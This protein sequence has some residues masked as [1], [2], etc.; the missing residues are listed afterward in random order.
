MILALECAGGRSAWPLRQAAAL[1]G[2]MK[3]NTPTLAP[4]R[5]GGKRRPEPES[6]QGVR[7][8]LRQAGGDDEPL[9]ISDTAFGCFTIDHLELILGKV[10]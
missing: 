4:G 1:L 6:A 10:N 9:E 5:I 8:F 2:G 3:A 7:R